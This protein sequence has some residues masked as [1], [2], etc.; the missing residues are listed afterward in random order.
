MHTRSCRLPE[1]LD[2][3]V[4]AATRERGVFQS[5]LIRRSIEFYISENPDG[6]QAFAEGS[7]R[8]RGGTPDDQR[9]GQEGADEPEADMSGVYDPTEGM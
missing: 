1:R 7:A 9:S 6:I 4:E 5:E 3:R 8:S 2:D